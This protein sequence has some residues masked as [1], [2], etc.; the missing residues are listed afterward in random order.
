M[1]NNRTATA[2]FLMY[3]QSIST[4]APQSIMPN[5]STTKTGFQPVMGQQNSQIQTSVVNRQS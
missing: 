1:T 2:K 4:S 5:T 3:N